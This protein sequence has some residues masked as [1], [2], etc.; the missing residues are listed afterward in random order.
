MSPT[1]AAGSRQRPSQAVRDSFGEDSA[2]TVAA[3]T[4]G[5]GLSLPAAP[6]VGGPEDAQHGDIDEN[7][8]RHH[9][10]GGGPFAFSRNSAGLRPGHVLEVGEEIEHRDPERE[11]AEDQ[12][13]A[14]EFIYARDRD[15]Y[16]RQEGD[17]ENAEPPHERQAHHAGGHPDQTRCGRAPR[18]PRRPRR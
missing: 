10:E 3:D 7:Q 4:P 9:G 15:T 8:C 6:R 13:S 2:R 1:S 16:Q 11:H 14:G 12:T 5:D 17:H 18:R